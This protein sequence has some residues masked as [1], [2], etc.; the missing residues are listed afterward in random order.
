MEGREN[1]CGRQDFVEELRKEAVGVAGLL[2]GHLQAVRQLSKELELWEEAFHSCGLHP[3]LLQ[4]RKS[5]VSTRSMCLQLR[6][7][8]F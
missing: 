1:I 7:R 3:T 8:L 6:L 2:E 5:Q 4:L